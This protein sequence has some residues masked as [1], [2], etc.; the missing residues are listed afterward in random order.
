MKA[1]LLC[2]G[3]GTRLGPHTRSRPKC[4][5]PVAGRP[6]VERTVDWLRD[7]GIDDLTMNLHHRPAVIEQHFGDGAGHGVRMSYSYEPEL[8]GTAGALRPVANRFADDRFLVVYADNLIECNLDRLTQLHEQLDALVTVALFTRA[9]VS[10]SGVAV[11]D[12]DGRM[13]YFREKPP[14]GDVPSNWVSA[15][16]LLCEPR[17]LDYVPQGRPS[18]FGA[19]VLPAVIA[20]GETVGGYRMGPDESLLWIDTPAELAAVDERLRRREALA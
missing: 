9:D 13:R 1:L 10:A 3:L 6:L 20:A 11:V 2:A 16:L 17:L 18:D 19:D 15:G 14:A 7:H 4:M 5:V 8:L 12:D